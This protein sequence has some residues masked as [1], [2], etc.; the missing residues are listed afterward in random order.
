MTPAT[1]WEECATIAL[2]QIVQGQLYCSGEVIIVLSLADRAAVE[3]NEAKRSRT[4]LCQHRL[5]Q[6]RGAQYKEHKPLV[7]LQTVRHVNP[8]CNLYDVVAW[9]T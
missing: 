4:R 1:H 5:S 9:L 2:L 3:M 8:S 6:S 7:Q